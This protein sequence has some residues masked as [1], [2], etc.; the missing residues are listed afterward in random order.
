MHEALVE[1]AEHD[2]DRDE[3]CENENGLVAQRV[4]DGPCGSPKSAMY[5]RRKSDVVGRFADRRRSVG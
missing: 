1:N 4:V 2:I 3:G 5:R